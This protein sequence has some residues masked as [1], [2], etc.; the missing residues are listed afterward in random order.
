VAIESLA[1]RKR[2]GVIILKNKSN[3]TKENPLA[4]ECR[5]FGYEPNQG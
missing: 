3:I 5:G 4:R 1:Y 2:K